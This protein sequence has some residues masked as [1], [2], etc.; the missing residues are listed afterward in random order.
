MIT[1]V[2]FSFQYGIYYAPNKHFR[3]MNIIKIMKNEEL[4]NFIS[5]EL[6]QAHCASDDN[7]A[8]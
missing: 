4:Y 5:I 7:Y 2:R 6:A 8:I 1:S 3:G